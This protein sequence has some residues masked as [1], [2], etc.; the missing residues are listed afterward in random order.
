MVHPAIE[1]MRDARKERRED[2]QEVMDSH[3]GSVTATILAF[4]A[5]QQQAMLDP[6]MPVE[7]DPLELETAEL[8]DDGDVMDD[9][10]I[11]PI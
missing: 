2:L 6:T 10:A 9:S 5:A 7:V 3:I 8:V 4:G 1:L 11:S